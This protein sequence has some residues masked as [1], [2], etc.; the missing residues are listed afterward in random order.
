MS[1]RPATQIV[2]DDDAVVHV[3][4]GRSGSR[5]ILTATDTRHSGERQVLLT[6]AQAED[7][8][9]FLLDGPGD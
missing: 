6:R 2:G 3:T 4:W 1:E 8:G 5:L 7:L 9:R